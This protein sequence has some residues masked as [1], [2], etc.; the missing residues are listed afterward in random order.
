MHLVQTVLMAWSS[1][2]ASMAHPECRQRG[3]EPSPGTDLLLGVEESLLT[4]C[5]IRTWFP[6]TVRMLRPSR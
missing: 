5:D 1:V 6:R 2:P 4:D 3:C